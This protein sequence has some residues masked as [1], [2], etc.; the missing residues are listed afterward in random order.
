MLAYHRSFSSDIENTN[1]TCFASHMILFQAHYN[2]KPSLYA[3]CFYWMLSEFISP[4]EW[5]LMGM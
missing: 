1:E 3:K 2:K 5:D 4:I